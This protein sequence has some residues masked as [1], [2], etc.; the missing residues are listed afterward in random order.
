MKH[1]ITFILVLC[2]PLYMISQEI[3]YP[4]S[5]Q[6]RAR[7]VVAE[8]GAVPLIICNEKEMSLALIL[9]PPLNINP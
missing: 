5:I 8:F 9:S 2:S 6:E 1:I 3:I 4:D 7:K